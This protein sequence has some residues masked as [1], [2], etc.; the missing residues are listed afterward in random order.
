MMQLKPEHKV[1][2][3]IVADLNT[4]QPRLDKSWNHLL[5]ERYYSNPLQITDSIII[6]SQTSGTFRR[7]QH[8]KIF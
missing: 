7:C 1:G 8:Y 6:C 5:L 2:R 3:L 4:D